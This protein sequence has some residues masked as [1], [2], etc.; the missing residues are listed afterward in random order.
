MQRSFVLCAAQAELIRWEGY[1]SE[2]GYLTGSEFN[3]ADILLAVSLTVYWRL[4]YDLVQFPKLKAYRERCE[5]GSWG[6]M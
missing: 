6:S 3:L 1:V 5:V 4:G 2:E